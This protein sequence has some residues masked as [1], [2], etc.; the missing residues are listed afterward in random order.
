MAESPNLERRMRKLILWGGAATVLLFAVSCSI[1]KDQAPATPTGPLFARGPKQVKSVVVSPSSASIVV[2]ATRALSAT[3]SPGGTGATVTWTSTNDAV[4]T[5]STSGVVTGVAA[6]TATVRATAGGV[7]GSSAITV[8]AAPPPP[9]PGVVLVGT[10]DIAVCG[11]TGDDQTAALLDGIDGTVFT[12][13]DNAYE[14]GT[15]AEYTNCYQ[16]SWG[17]HLARTRPSAGN[18]EYNTPGA[19]GYY[20]YYGAAAGDPLKGY[21]SY[22][23]GDWHIIVLNTNSN[24]VAIG[25]AAGSTQEQWLRSD[26]QLNSK[27]CTLAYW[28]HPRFSS[29]SGHGNNSGMTALWQALY[30]ANADVVLNGHEH[31]YERFAPQTPSGSADA[32]RGI[33][34]FT[35]GTGGREPGAIGTIKA[36][37]E[38]RNGGTYGVLK[39]TLRAGSYDW[40]FVPVAGKTFTD[41]G[42]GNCH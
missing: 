30:D 13:G 10:G 9:G 19:T 23:L 16:P 28:H 37:S 35:V 24:C 27:P 39:L 36:N 41:T 8:T 5:V 38:V 20:G 34:Q 1:Q 29:G 6:G 31:I 11:S 33:R 21:Y 4:A 40:Q 7:S 17:R 2:G 42:S 22:D 18:H 15:T 12:L 25:C 26:L 14:N 3:V 32:V